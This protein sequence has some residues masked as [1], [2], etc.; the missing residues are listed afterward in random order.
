MR[1]T[2]MTICY[3]REKLECGE[4]SDNSKEYASILHA[5]PGMQLSLVLEGAA[6]R[7]NRHRLYSGTFI[8]GVM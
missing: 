8:C 5:A 6:A 1:S 4:G 2:A 7:T 3:I